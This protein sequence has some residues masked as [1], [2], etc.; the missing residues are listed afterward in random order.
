MTTAPAQSTS[1]PAERPLGVAEHFMWLMNQNRPT[2]SAT[3][4]EVAG[5][6]EVHGWRTALNTLQRHHALLGAR[7]RDSGNGPRLSFGHAAQI[8]LRV[9]DL[10]ATG[11]QQEL[12]TEMRHGVDAAAMPPVR[13]VLL[14]SPERCALVLVGHHAVVDGLSQAFLVRD[15]LTL[16]SGGSIEGAAEGHPGHPVD[17]FLA[18]EIAAAATTLPSDMDIPLSDRP[19]IYRTPDP[20]AALSIDAA[21]LSRPQTAA[22]RERARAEGTTV[23][24]AVAAAA[25]GAA[26]ELNAAWSTVPLRVHSPLSLRGLLPAPAEGMGNI[27]APATTAQVGKWSDPW[28]AARSFTDTLAPF[29][30]KSA[31]LQSLALWTG[32]F[33]NRP[34]PADMAGMLAAAA[35]HELLL[36]NLGALP[37]GTSYGSLTLKSLWGPSVLFGFEGE[38]TLGLSALAG[39]LRIL[40]TSFSPVPELLELTRERLLS[41]I[42]GTG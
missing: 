29:R 4:I 5:P 39:T 10:A 37:I 31:L 25:L 27:L 28:E 6:T 36:T 1:M 22:L 15:L 34:A 17:H 38:Q 41:A 2:H 21:A 8:P 24:G 32:V 16:V 26:A 7:I 42:G 9:T 23:H 14:Y 30:H 18:R 33:Q 13:A 35:P 11:W 40:H 20:D 19:G 12:A 3:A